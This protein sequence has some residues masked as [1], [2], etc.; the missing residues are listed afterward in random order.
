MEQVSEALDLA[1]GAIIALMQM[2]E[3]AVINAQMTHSSQINWLFTCRRHLSTI[4]DAIEQYRALPEPTPPDLDQQYE[5][6]SESFVVVQNRIDYLIDDDTSYEYDEEEFGED[7]PRGYDADTIEHHTRIVTMGKHRDHFEQS[8]CT[9]C[10]TDFALHDRLRLLP[11]SHVYHVDCVADWLA[12]RK[13]CPICL[14]DIAAS[15]PTAPG[16]RILNRMA[17]PPLRRSKRLRGLDP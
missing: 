4:I 3:P 1:G 8:K 13:T 2:L 17:D 12:K 9:I 10:L 14:A 7:V 15:P 11:C 16:R 5:F 6:V